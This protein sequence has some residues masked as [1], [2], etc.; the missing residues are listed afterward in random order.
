MR[1]LRTASLP[2]GEG[3]HLHHHLLS[4]HQHRPLTQLQHRPLPQLQHRQSKQYPWQLHFLRLKATSPTSW[5]TL[6]APPRHSY[7]L[8]RV[9][10][11][12]PQSLKPHQVGTK[13]L[14]TR[15]YSLPSPPHHH[16]ARKPNLINQFKRVV[17]RVS[18][19]LLQHLH[20]QRLQAFPS[21][22]KESGGPSRLYRPG[23]RK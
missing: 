19:R 22:S 23:S 8:E 10:L 7:L 2:K 21:R 13:A 9:L 18:T 20:Q 4:Q 12:L 1:Q 14:I 16:H 3:W 17:V 6:R 5:R 11:Q 15:Q